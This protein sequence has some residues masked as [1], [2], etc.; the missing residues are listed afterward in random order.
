MRIS[1]VLVAA[2]LGACST[3]APRDSSDV[4]ERQA[5]LRA[6][7]QADAAVRQ[8]RLLKEQEELKRV[9]DERKRRD[10]VPAAQI[11]P[12]AQPGIDG[13][14]LKDP[15]AAIDIPADLW[16]QRSVYYDYDSYSVKAEYQPL[17]EAHASLLRARPDLQINVEGNCDERGSR[18]YNLALGQRRAEVV[19]RSLVLLGA[20]AQQISTVSFGS[21]KPKSDG[22]AEQDLAENRRSDLVYVGTAPTK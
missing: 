15:A 5:A 17:L 6:Q 9:L 14:A 12:L 3:G 7:Q 22:S 1:L 20:S 18:E 19:K 2:T 21:E 11:N 16:A 8:A 13:R 10:Q 4:L